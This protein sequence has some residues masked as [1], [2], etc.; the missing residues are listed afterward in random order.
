MISPS[1]L[2]PALSL[3][4]AVAATVRTPADAAP[5]AAAAADRCLLVVHRTGRAAARRLALAARTRPRERPTAAAARARSPTLTAAVA[6]PTTIA[7]TAAIAI[8][9]TTTASAAAT[10]VAVAT[11]LRTGRPAVAGHLDAQLPAVQH[12]TVH[13]LQRVLGVA[14]VVEPVRWKWNEPNKYR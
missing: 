4:S 3:I 11:R 14:L 7:A 2:S 1:P 13:R 5:L 6:R 8:S 10:A 12:A 9:A